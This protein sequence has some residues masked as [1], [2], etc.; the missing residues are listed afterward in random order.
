[1]GKTEALKD[2]IL[3]I[4][5]LP[6]IYKYYDTQNTLLYIGKAK[7]LKK[8][9]SSYF[10]KQHFENRKTEVLVSKICRLEFTVVK[11]EID[12]LLLENSLIKEFR[13]RYNI[14]LKD[15]KSFPVIRVT[16]ERF[17]KIYAMRNPINDGSDYF[18]PYSSPHVM[19]IVLD[20]VK[21]IYPIRNCNY[22]LSKKNIEAN[23]FKVCLEYQI[24]NCKGACEGF[25]TELEYMES[26]SRIKNI[27]RG[28]LSEVKNHLKG[29][30]LKASSQLQFEQAN[31]FK[32]KLDKLINYQGRTTVVS[33]TITNVDVFN[34]SSSN[35]FA[36]VNY[37]KIV[38]GMII[39]SQTIEY[40]KVLDET[41]QEVLE[42]AIFELRER[43]K[44]TAKE[45]IVSHKLELS[46]EG[47]KFTNPKAGDRKKLLEISMSNLLHFKK[48]KLEQYDK[49][50][51]EL[52]INRLMNL[53]QSDLKLKVMPKYIECFDNSNIQGHFPV[54]ACVVFRNGKPS[55]KEYRIF[56]IKTVEGPNDFATMEEVITRRYTRL[57][58]ENSELPD[59]VIIDGGKGQLSSAV[60][61]MQRVGVFG[62]FAVIGIAKRLEELYY[63]ED[64]LP[65]YIDKKSETLK[66]IQQLRD[67]A[68]RF[69]ITKH[70]DLRSKGSLGTELTQING[71]GTETAKRLLQVFKSIKNIKSQT[72]ESISTVVGK[73][74]AKVVMDALMKD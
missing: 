68:H 30:M 55:K 31:R 69:G 70:R 47:L 25:E 73:A 16:N 41:D 42:M 8:R 59:L 1:M 62:K 54:S 44:S 35:Q 36:F 10:T 40:R 34:I 13:P 2:S 20:L 65:L 43:Y 39:Q 9:V 3:N 38:N 72:F 60:E 15:D 57:L 33:I 61:A 53:M 23:K 58:N 7:N 64:A 6:G 51:P 46:I 56:N 18:G 67:E 17:P 24:G 32:Y 48:E 37:L 74:K 11:T 29:E 45:I 49:L 19:H 21:Q 63:P 5:E 22:V 27:L 66:I 52:R 4:P 71:I 26:I 14:A 12:A 50:D 28:N